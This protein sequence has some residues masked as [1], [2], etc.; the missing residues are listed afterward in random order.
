MKKIIKPQGMAD[1]AQPQPQQPPQQQQQH[2]DLIKVAQIRLRVRGLKI[3][4]KNWLHNTEPLRFKVSPTKSHYFFRWDNN[5]EFTECV[6]V[7]IP[8]GKVWYDHDRFYW[9]VTHEYLEVILWLLNQYIGGNFQEYAEL[10]PDTPVTCKCTWKGWLSTCYAAQSV[11]CP[12][13]MAHLVIR[14]NFY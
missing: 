13:C 12:R 9:V 8:P 1:R 14:R 3:P 7:A 5:E 10:L 2:A 6:K 4:K 11:K